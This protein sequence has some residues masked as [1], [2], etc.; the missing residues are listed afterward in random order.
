MGS[1]LSKRVQ[2][3]PDLGFT[4]GQPCRWQNEFPLDLPLCRSCRGCSSCAGA[5]FVGPVYY[6]I[7]S[8]R[9]MSQVDPFGCH[10]LTDCASCV[11]KAIIVDYPCYW[12]EI[13]G[14]C[15][16]VRLLT[17]YAG[18]TDRPHDAV[19]SDSLFQMPR[20][21]LWCRH[22][23]RHLQTT[24]ASLCLLS[25]TA[26]TKRSPSARPWR[27]RWHE[28]AAVLSAPSSGGARE[29]VLPPGCS[30]QHGNDKDTWYL[31][32]SREV[33]LPRWRGSSGLRFN[34]GCIWLANP[35]RPYLC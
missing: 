14:A 28:L 2:S 33:P 10:K 27:R 12:C 4:A 13:D 6:S 21:A 16:D 3:D 32:G 17:L 1:H 9:M 7:A 11:E 15:H 30:S 29:R 31:L 35:Y 22:A 26:H 23:P 34:I 5:R 18:P 20:S 19:A 8:G 24:N 25:R